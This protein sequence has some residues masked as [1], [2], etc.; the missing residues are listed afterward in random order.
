MLE[1][2]GL[3]QLEHL[4]SNANLLPRAS[5]LRKHILV[6]LLLGLK[7]YPSLSRN[8]SSIT[9]HLVVYPCLRIRSTNIQYCIFTILQQMEMNTSGRNGYL[10][11]H[12]ELL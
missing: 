1:N 8:Y 6:L 12:N 11:H 4:P 7:L 3:T 10:F 5:R 9:S 2:I